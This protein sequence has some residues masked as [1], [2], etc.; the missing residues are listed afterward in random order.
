MYVHLNGWVDLVT[1][2]L[3]VFFGYAQNHWSS[4]KLLFLPLHK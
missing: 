3:L 1:A 4:G 2:E